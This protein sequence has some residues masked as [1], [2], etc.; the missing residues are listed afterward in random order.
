MSAVSDR[1]TGG[2]MAE[3]GGYIGL[4]LIA[5]L[6]YCVWRFRRRREILMTAG[7][8]II[9]EVLS[10]GPTLVVYGH[11]THVPLPWDLLGRLPMM[12]D[13]LPVRL[14]LYVTMFAAMTLAI[15]VAAFSGDDTRHGSDSSKT[16]RDGHRPWFSPRI[17]AGVLVAASVCSLIPR[18]PVT[19][20]P[21]SASTP[22]F[23]TSDAALAIP[24][25]AVV[26]TYPLGVFPVIPSIL[27][28]ITDHYRWKTIGGYGFIPN[29]PTS[30]IGIPPFQSPR[31]VYLFLVD[32]TVSKKVPDVFGPPPKLDALLVSQF[33][34]YLHRDHVNDIVLAPRSAGS[35]QALALFTRALGEPRL[36]GGVD[37]WTN[38]PG[39]LRPHEVVAPA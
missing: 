12:D 39:L 1:F 15:A 9:A 38:V 27:W 20:M 23:F 18:W 33:R 24:K 10:F 7:L 37:L 4:P 30:T 11:N 16:R 5:L 2:G 35:T 34:A 29:G 14:S 25:G 21:N 28:Q 8:A 32:W 17:V 13:V 19:S 26:L 3:A 31:S 36:I 22:T 6:V